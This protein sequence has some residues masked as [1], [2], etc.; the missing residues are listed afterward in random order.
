MTYLREP[1]APTLRL[2]A[3]ACDAHCH[4]FGPAAE[5]PYSADAPFIPADAPRETLFALH[6]R[7]GIE[8]CALVQSVVH[9]RDHRAIAAALRAKRGAYVGVAL[10][11]V[12]A[13]DAE[14]AALHAQGFRGTRF[15]F[16]RHLGVGT[17]I[18][19]VIAMT[20]RLA[21]LGWHLQ[22][23]PD[24]SL[25]EAMTPWL[26]RSAVPVVVDHMGR[27]DARLGPDQAPFR[28]LCALVRHRNIWVKLSGCDRAAGD[29]PPYGAAAALARRVL[30]ISGERAVWGTD[31]P[32]P[33]HTHI[34]DD[35]TLTDLIGEI[36]P[37][38]AL[39]QAL[40]VDNPQRLY[41]FPVQV[42]TEVA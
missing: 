2:P 24:P 20:P 11:P 30:E 10:A 6:R 33:S 4:I 28:A 18:E 32:H 12:D 1:T 35:G 40:L 42:P 38:P 9:Q 8:R 25:I 22:I 14:L 31:W 17:P 34:P 39:R 41:Q 37:T 13:G 16:M 26:L 29:G 36:A 27:I 23:H 5:F 7:M 21:A 15:N 19:Q 3:G